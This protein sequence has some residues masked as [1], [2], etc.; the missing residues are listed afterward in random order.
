MIAVCITTFVVAVLGIKEYYL[1]KNAGFGMREIKKRIEVTSGPNNLGAFFCYYSPFIFAYLLMHIKHPL[2]WF[3]ELPVFLAIMQAMRLTFSRGAQLGFA[4]AVLACLY[5]RKRLFFI[6]AVVPVITLMFFIPALIPKQCY[7][8]LG[9]T[10]SQ[11]RA[12]KTGSFEGG[13]DKSGADRIRIWKAGLEIISDYPFFGVGY[14]N[15]RQVI[16]EYMGYRHG[17]TKRDPHNTYLSIAAEM[18]IPALAVFLWVMVLMMKTGLYVYRRTEDMSLKVYAL[19]Y[20]GA[21]V[22]LLISNMFGSRLDSAE[23]TAQF[24]LLTGGIYVAREIV[25][26]ELDEREEKN[27]G[28]THPTGER[29]ANDRSYL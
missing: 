20:V 14:K 23:I 21:M 18:G 8:R 13:L 5:L 1:D 17:F 3:R 10:Y 16:G 6:L 19:G 26:K 27:S 15:F 4:A 29:I 22:G 24:W 25:Q 11:E 2:T 9:K 28:P 7:G 12:Q